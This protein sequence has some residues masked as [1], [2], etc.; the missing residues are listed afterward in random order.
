MCL[1][2]DKIKDE[3]VIITVKDKTTLMKYEFLKLYYTKWNDVIKQTY[4]F[5]VDTHAG[6]GIVNYI[7]SGTLF[8]EDQIKQIYGSPL[9]ALLKTIRLSD[10]LTL[11]FNEVNE[12]RFIFL[13]EQIE[14]VKQ[15]GIRLFRKDRT[16]RY[17]KIDSQRTKKME[18]FEY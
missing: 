2:S 9:I 8:Q 5:I 4:R 3:D 15:N 10:K 11:I 13:N 6:S 17:H 12:K 1:A 7:P 16:I 18:S 14:N